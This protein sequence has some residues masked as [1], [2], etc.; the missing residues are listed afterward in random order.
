[1]EIFEIL[2]KIENLIKSEDLK[3]TENKTET[4]GQP[5]ENPAKSVFSLV[6]SFFLNIL[7]A[8]FKIIAKYLKKEIVATIKKDARLLAFIL[9]IMGVLLVFFSV[10]WLFIS[11]AVAVYFQ[12]KGHSIL[13]SIIY[14][15][16]FQTISFI[17]LGFIAFISSKKIKSLKMLKSLSEDK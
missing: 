10:L 9:S 6:L 8:P 15:V 11:I 12:E 7:K 1:M 16:I 13:M 14:S 3:S 17:I 2:D 4:E 5:N